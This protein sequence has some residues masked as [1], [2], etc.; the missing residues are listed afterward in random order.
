MGSLTNLD[1]KGTQI[2]N[3]YADLLK[4]KVALDTTQREQEKYLADAYRQRLLD[5]RATEE[6]NRK[7]ADRE[8][9]IQVQQLLSDTVDHLYAK[10]QKFSDGGVGLQALSNALGTGTQPTGTPTT[11]ASGAGVTTPATAYN[12]PIIKTTTK[13]EFPNVPIDYKV[14]TGQKEVAAPYVEGKDSSY[15]RHQINLLKDKIKEQLAGT[16]SI[17]DPVAKNKAILDINK[18]YDTDYKEIMRDKSKPKTQVVGGVIQN[19]Q[20]TFDDLD[21]GTALTKDGKRAGKDTP[22]NKTYV[23]D[24]VTKNLV[25][26]AKAMEAGTKVGLGEETKTVETVVGT[27]KTTVPGL[28]AMMASAYKEGSNPK[29]VQAIGQNIQT[30]YR[31]LL[32]SLPK[33]NSAKRDEL[34]NIALALYADKGLDPNDYDVSKVVDSL[35]PRT[36]MS[37]QQKAAVN[38]QLDMLHR[39]MDQINKNR[40]F[41]LKEKELALHEATKRA[42]LGLRQA[43]FAWR[44][45]DAKANRAV[46][47]A[48]IS[49][50][51]T[52]LPKESKFS[53]VYGSNLLKDLSDTIGAKDAN[54]AMKAADAIQREYGLDPETT[55]ALLK[56]SIEVR[57]F[58]DSNWVPK[59]LQ[60]SLVQGLFAKRQQ[61]L[62]EAYGGINRVPT[63]VLTK[64][65]NAIINNTRKIISPYE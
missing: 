16:A 59:N 29:E 40:E 6:Y 60:D 25:P 38:A 52:V 17:L 24:T 21:L 57:T 18:A 47:M 62:A 65:K 48:R 43:E 42:E 32:E 44:K 22:V 46:D 37:E 8:G 56:G 14:I 5:D 23:R 53:S 9:R 11:G 61:E 55:A 45:E 1:F 30:Q 39:Q 20:T 27:R 31:N 49:A 41:G 2:D 34:R 10:D 3:P 28:S 63:S 13:R 58:G 50:T 35:L 33:D 64:E 19:R 7:K 12:E 4:T 51:K 54:R 15:R 36:E 26:L